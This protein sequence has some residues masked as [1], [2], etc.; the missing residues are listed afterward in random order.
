MVCAIFISGVLGSAGTTP[1]VPGM[2][3]HALRGGDYDVPATPEV[4]GDEATYNE[5]CKLVRAYA[6]WALFLQ[7]LDDALHVLGQAVEMLLRRR[8]KDARRL[9]AD[10]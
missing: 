8:I 5:V 9:G 7:P 10:N 4:V 1:M 2:G 6:V 3:V